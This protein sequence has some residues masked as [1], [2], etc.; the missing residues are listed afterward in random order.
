MKTT[1]V[2]GLC[3]VEPWPGELQVVP[4]EPAP[5][6]MG[7]SA[8]RPVPADV[9]LRRTCVDDTAGLTSMLAELSPASSF[10]RFLTGLGRPSDRLVDRLLHRDSTHGAW[11]AVV[12]DSPVGHIMWALADDAVELG[13]VVTDAWQRRGIGRWLVQVA[14]AEAA[15]A[16]AVAVRLD[17]HVDNRRVVAMLR[18]ALPDA[19]VTREAELLTFRSPM[20]ATMRV[21]PESLEA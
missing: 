21:R 14:L 7:V 2:S 20:L 15:V 6:W 10:F 3:P 9:R 4:A 5:P 18:R 8:G 11:L 1:Q 19:R 17:V 12:G 16:G 13:V